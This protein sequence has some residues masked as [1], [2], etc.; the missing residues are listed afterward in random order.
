MVSRSLAQKT[1][2]RDPC[3]VKQTRVREKLGERVLWETGREGSTSEHVDSGESP[4]PIFYFFGS[5]RRLPHSA[6]SMLISCSGELV[7]ATAELVYRY[8]FASSL[9]VEAGTP[10]LRLAASLGKAAA[11]HFFEGRLVAPRAFGDLMLVLSNIVRANFFRPL[12][13]AMLD[14]VIT[15]STSKLRF[16]G[17]SGCCGAYVMTAIPA[18]AIDGQFLQR[19]TTN[20]DFNDPM[21][22]AL[23]RLNDRQSTQLSVGAEAMSLASG[24][25]KVVEKKVRLPSRWVRGFCE[26]HIYQSRLE[27]HAELTGMQARQLMQLTPRS[28]ARR[29]LYLQT[30]SDGARWSTAESPASIR[31][32][33]AHRLCIIEPLIRQAS[34]L[35]IWVD[36]DSHVSAWIVGNPSGTL[37]LMLSPDVERGFSGEG[38]ALQEIS[39]SEGRQHL[40]SIR[41]Q[42]KWQ[43]ALRV[44]ELANEA[45]IDSGT[46]EQALSVLGTQGAVGFDLSDQAYFHRELPFSNEAIEKY[47]S[48]LQ[49]AR[50]LAANT[51]ATRVPGAGPDQVFDVRSDDSVYRVTLMASGEWRCT[52][53]WYGKHRGQRGPCKHLLAVR[54]QTSEE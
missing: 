9:E 25:D 2:R 7:A 16:E 8:P 49:G 21:R 33:G 20:V 53:P 34:S 4:L 52:C 35:R 44:Q 14:P 17:F 48:R 54:L 3:D 22:A 40:A 39:A 5:Y 47:Q 30:R 10:R 36:R 11:P 24:A 41:A 38:Q 19:G 12:T 45:S 1:V 42:L 15:A 32:G 13:P 27:P 43:D 28:P 46:V 50:E 26:S 18:A 37:M 31:V 51:F 29:P 6:Q 23:T